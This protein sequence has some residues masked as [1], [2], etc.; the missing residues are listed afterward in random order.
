MGWSISID[1]FD[2]FNCYARNGNNCNLLMWHLYVFWMECAIPFIRYSH[3]V[4]LSTYVLYLCLF[5]CVGFYVIY[6]YYI[7]LFCSMHFHS[8][9]PCRPASSICIPTLSPFN[10]LLI[11]EFSQRERRSAWSFAIISTFFINL[12]YEFL[13]PLLLF[14]RPLLLLWLF[15]WWT[16]VH[17][18]L[19]MRSLYSQRN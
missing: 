14:V 11:C 9:L 2:Y 18:P 16:R 17:T 19:Y 15:N 7:G 3:A 1:V 8:P 12:P 13:P 4:W 10:I 6:I 5:Q